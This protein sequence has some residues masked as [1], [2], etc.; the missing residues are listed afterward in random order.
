MTGSSFINEYL[1]TY[2]DEL[3]YK[4]FYRAIFPIG[5]LE[6][7]GASGSTGL[8]NALAL[9]I[10][11]QEDKAKVKKYII[12]DE[13][14]QLDELVTHDNFIIISPISITVNNLINRAKT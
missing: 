13:L 3:N 4:E 6:P 10:I 8:Y 9:E 5:T 2:F 11:P 12:T 7:K 1:S 14:E